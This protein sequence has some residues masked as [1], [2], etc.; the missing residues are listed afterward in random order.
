MVLFSSVTSKINPVTDC[1]IITND[2]LIHAQIIKVAFHPY[3][4][5]L[6][7]LEAAKPVQP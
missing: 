3:E 4:A 5:V 7:Y 6:P 1:H 2:N